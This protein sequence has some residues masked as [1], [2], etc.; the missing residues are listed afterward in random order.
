MWKNGGNNLKLKRRICKNLNSNKFRIR[1]WI[2]K[3]VK[4]FIGIEFL[5]IKKF[6]WKKSYSNSWNMFNRKIK[7]HKWIKLL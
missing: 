7:S 1:K 4:R 5:R 6:I 3:I 2:V